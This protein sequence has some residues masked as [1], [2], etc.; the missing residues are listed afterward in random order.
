MPAPHPYCDSI[1]AEN[2]ARRCGYDEYAARGYCGIEC[3]SVADCGVA[4][5]CFPVQLNLCTCFEEQDAQNFTPNTTRRTQ[6]VWYTSNAEYFLEAK[7]T[8]DPYFLSAQG[9]GSPAGSP[10]TASTGFAASKAGVLAAV[11][12]GAAFIVM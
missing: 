11:I 8:I 10:T 9:T 6:E 4:E 7:K 1:N 12:V 3:E 2:V 5:D